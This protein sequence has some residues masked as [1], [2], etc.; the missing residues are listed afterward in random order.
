MFGSRH[1]TELVSEMFVRGIGFTYAVAFASLSGQII[2]LMGARG[3]EPAA[4]LLSQIDQNP[5]GLSALD[6]PSWLWILGASDNALRGVCIAGA[7]CS[8]LVVAG[9]LPRLSLFAAWSLYLSL[10]SFGGVFLSYQWD[11]LLLECGI[12]GLFVATRR[13]P[14]GIWVARALCL[15]LMLLSGVV[16]LTS[17][18]PTWRD[19]SAMSYHF[20][21]QPLPAWPALFAN[22]LPEGIKAAMTFASLA[23]ELVAPIFIFAPRRA[24]L[25]AAAALALLQVMIAATGTY[26]FFNMLSL[27]LCASLLDDDALLRLVPKRLRAI[28]QQVDSHA[29]EEPE[30]VDTSRLARP[31]RGVHVAL[32]TLLLVAS[33]CVSIR[34]YV[35]FPELVRE[36]LAVLAPL[37][38]VNRYGLFAVMTTERNEIGLEGS[39]D[40]VHWREYELP[41][42]PGR[43]DE[44]PGFATPH[45]PRLD[46]QVWFAA[47]S[48]CERQPWLHRLMKRLLEGSPDVL[49]LFANNPFP[50]GPP[51]FIRT[52]LAKYRFAPV[53][54]LVHGQWWTREPIGEYCPTVTLRAGELVRGR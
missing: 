37:R 19:L 31:R 16:K 35:P 41:W 21:T 24:R 38:S 3:I 46:W 25:I 5:E 33:L 11:T 15:K 48:R 17:G 51:R 12:V 49:D 29:A 53:A 13:S 47:L 54:A 43:L 1:R 44:M 4:E 14:I 30:H 39:A 23:I 26:G 6:F 32:A 27:L 45:M 8:L 50:N 10:C 2:G 7:L 22:A 9:K 18:D 42:K 40:G 20:W 52:P 34:R 36:S 28:Q